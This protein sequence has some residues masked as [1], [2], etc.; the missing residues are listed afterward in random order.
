MDDSGEFVAT[1]DL[2]GPVKGAQELSRRLAGSAEVQDCV[3]AQWFRHAQG[4]HETDADA[5]TLGGLRSRFQASGRDFRALM[6][7]LTETPA[8]RQRRVAAEP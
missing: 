5:C 8:F 6:L 3:V 2:D 4:R 1:R 7:A